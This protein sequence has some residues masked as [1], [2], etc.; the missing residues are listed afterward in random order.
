MLAMTT[1]N[2]N[3][4]AS[5]APITVR[6]TNPGFYDNVYRFRGDVFRIPTEQ[7]FSSRW[8]ERVDPDSPKT[9]ASESARPAGHEPTGAA[10]VLGD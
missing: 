4:A 6:A 7:L 1:T 3:A 2:K 9:I 5:P 8:M 10:H